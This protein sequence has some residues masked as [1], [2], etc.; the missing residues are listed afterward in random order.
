MVWRPTLAAVRA[1]GHP[2]TAS[3]RAR[4]GARAIDRGMT[5]AAALAA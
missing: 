5:I 1:P 4:I 3:S 2:S